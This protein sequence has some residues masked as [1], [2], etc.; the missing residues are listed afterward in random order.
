MATVQSQRFVIPI[1]SEKVEETVQ[2]AWKEAKPVAESLPRPQSLS[3]RFFPTDRCITTI[4]R[5]KEEYPREVAY[6]STTL[7][8]TSDMSQELTPFIPSPSQRK[9]KKFRRGGYVVFPGISHTG[10]PPLVIKPLH[11]SG[12]VKLGGYTIDSHHYY[13][14]V[15][16]SDIYVP[17]GG[18]LVMLVISNFEF[19]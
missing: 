17:E 2:D 15:V 19:E 18:K 7:E 1:S 4:D 13:Y 11:V 3:A 14:V 6:P 8:C 10:E 9:I 12:D 16:K 5:I